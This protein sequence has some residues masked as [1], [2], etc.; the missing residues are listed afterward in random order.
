MHQRLLAFLISSASAGSVQAETI[1]VAL[2]GSG[3][4]S[5]IQEA[6][7]A[8]SDG[9][10]VLV[11]PGEYV[12]HEPIHFNPL[13]D[14]PG[15]PPAEVK[16]LSLRSNGGAAVT[17]IRLEA[18]PPSG[19]DI[20][21]SVVG[22]QEGETSASSIEGF[23]ITGA[24]QGAGIVCDGASPLI[25]GCHVIGNG[26]V[27]ILVGR[28]SP[29]IESC[30]VSRSR[31]SGVALN[32]CSAE[33][34]DCTMTENV[35]NG[36]SNYAG[37]SRITG[38]SVLSNGASGLSTS[39]EPGPSIDRC[40]LVG[41]GADN[42]G[43]GV[44][45]MGPVELAN[46]LIAAN[47][48]GPGNFG[49]AMASWQ[50]GA[51]RALHCTVADNFGYER[52]QGGLSCVNGGTIEL[53]NSIV[54]GNQPSSLCGTSSASILE[55]ENPRFV[56][57]GRYN[58]FRLKQ[59]TVLG[60]TEEVPD[61]VLDPGDYS[62]AEDSPALDR[63][64]PIP[65]AGQDILGAERPCG[66]AADLGAYERCVIEPTDCNMNGME[67]AEDIASGRSPDC[68]ANGSP[69]ECDVRHDR[70]VFSARSLEHRGGIESFAT[71]DVD[72]DGD[73]DV[74]VN[75]ADFSVLSVL[76]TMNGALEDWWSSSVTHP[77]KGF[78]AG[79]VDVDGDVDIVALGTN[80]LQVYQN[81]GAGLFNSIGEPPP[82]WP[83]DGTPVSGVL[84]DL[85]GDLR[86][87]F[88]GVGTAG[89]E[90]R[91]SIHLNRP[92][93]DFSSA[94]SFEIGGEALSIV[95]ADFT[96]DGRADLAM[97]GL[98]LDGEKPWARIAIAVEGDPLVELRPALDLEFEPSALAAADLDGDA[99]AD[100]AILGRTEGRV[101]L[102]FHRGGGSF[103]RG[104]SFPCGPEPRL[105]GAGDVTRDGLVDLVAAGGTTAV[106]VLPNLGDRS[107]GTAMEAPLPAVPTRMEVAD[108]D[109]DGR[110][111]IVTSDPG[112]GFL[113]VLGSTT[114]LASSEDRDLDGIP[115]ECGRRRFRRGDANTDARVNISDALC[116]LARLFGGQVDFCGRITEVACLEAADANNDGAID[117][118]DAVY[119]L[120]SLFLDGEALPA[121]GR[122]CGEDPDPRTDPKDLGC[123]QYD[124]C[125]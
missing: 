96:R 119:L 67:D 88:A 41:N 71:A 23:S 82:V 108:M 32:E 38:C 3:A 97:A 1:T 35:G 45:A 114:A 110:L 65:G 11:S 94:G 66:T 21:R 34:V 54:W 87:D 8:A 14:P 90:P 17:T 105:I 85:D 31:L 78:L 29:R 50:G 70:P 120:S 86:V 68:N 16:N 59:I 124:P 39:G 19:P 107:F 49:A 30:A 4:F 92:G 74:V 93:P 98:G 84:A 115:D 72:R 52:A 22:F 63:G 55:S 25:R 27:G 51:I 125:A 99:D 112:Q 7:D 116:V 118:S 81:K 123:R 102:L 62:L 80:E 28:G 18:S 121:P 12:V 111:D 24:I 103:D 101:T 33:V 48:V 26:W 83:L 6:I 46:C 9:D 109:G 53:E 36:I 75:S 47:T 57:R 73:L 10:T 44:E 40:K 69:D 76:K 100:L 13:R 43:G 89:G 113:T 56:R 106:F 58:F 60:Q 122:T 2:D 104:G 77:K 64:E 91:L 117:L 15:P 37:S 5:S 95:S 20:L 42:F 79:D 61:Y